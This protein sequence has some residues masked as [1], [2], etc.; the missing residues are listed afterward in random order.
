[1]YMDDS[2]IVCK[3]SILNRLSEYGK[4]LTCVYKQCTG[5]G[6]KLLST[7]YACKACHSLQH[8]LQVIPN[9]FGN[10]I[11]VYTCMVFLKTVR[12]AISYIQ[13]YIYVI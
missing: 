10:M 13:Y 4:A 7:T 2:S 12:T 8:K 6:G 9:N 11:S 5:I 1:M 3:C